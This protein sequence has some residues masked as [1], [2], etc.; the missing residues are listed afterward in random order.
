MIT[1]HDEYP[2]PATPSPDPYPRSGT[3]LSTSCEQGADATVIMAKTHHRSIRTAARYTRPGLAAV[4]QATELL[5][6]PQ[7]RG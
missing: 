2:H 4:T 7:R 1:N 5:D 3:S 6:P